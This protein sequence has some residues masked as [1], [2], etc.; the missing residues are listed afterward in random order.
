MID[1]K[2]GSEDPS[3]F[4]SREVKLLIGMLGS[5]QQSHQRSQL[6]YRMMTQCL[7]IRCNHNVS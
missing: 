1:K 2:E 7:L 6:R 5:E 3:H 4:P